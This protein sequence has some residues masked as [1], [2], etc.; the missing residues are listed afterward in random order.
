[1]TEMRTPQNA[2]IEDAVTLI[3]VAHPSERRAVAR[4]EIRAAVAEEREACAMVVDEY[5]RRCDKGEFD[6]I[7][8]ASWAVCDMASEDIRARGEG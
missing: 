6:S 7:P 4:R 1:M 2:D 8:E 5:Q 3:Q